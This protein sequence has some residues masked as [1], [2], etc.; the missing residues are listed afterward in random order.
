MRHAWGLT[1][2]EG[3]SFVVLTP[4]AA[5]LRER[6]MKHVLNKAPQQW[7]SHQLRAIV[8]GFALGLAALGGSVYAVMPGRATFGSAE[9]GG[10]FAMIGPDGRVVTNVDLV[11]RL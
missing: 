1:L 10:S 2:S 6:R 7:V 11:G 4:G 5:S 3:L 9:I 8:I